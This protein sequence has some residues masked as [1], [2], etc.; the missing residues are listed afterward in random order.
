[1]VSRMI[2]HHASGTGG[3]CHG[4]GSESPPECVGITSVPSEPS[5]CSSARITATGPPHTQPSALSAE[6]SSS[7][8]PGRTPSASKSASSEGIVTGPAVVC[9]MADSSD[10]AFAYVNLVLP[11]RAHLLDIIERLVAEIRVVQLGV[12]ATPR[13][14]RLVRALLDDRARLHHNN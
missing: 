6:C 8:M 2:C 10:I 9:R 7:V 5:S 12:V 13:Q 4:A 1:M 3:C 11:K 14:Q